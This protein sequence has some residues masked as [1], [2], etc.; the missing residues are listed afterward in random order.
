MIILS[1]TLLIGLRSLQQ[2]RTLWRLLILQI[3]RV[4]LTL[5][6]HAETSRENMAKRSFSPAIS[7]RPDRRRAIHA[8]YSYCR[9]ADDIVDR[10]GMVGDEITLAALDAWEA[11]IERPWHP[12]AVS[13]AETRATYGIPSQPAHDLLQ[14]V[15][16]DLEPVHFETWSA[17]REYCYQVAGTVGLLTAPVLGCE[18]E[19]ALP[20]AVDLGIAMQMTNIIRDVGEDIGL[21]RIYLPDEDLDQFGVDRSA[22]ENGVAT[23]DFDGL[24]AFEIAR[25][26]GYYE[27]GL[28]GVPAL[29]VF[30]Q[31]AVLT[32]ARLYGSILDRV[33]DQGFDVLSRRAYVPT[34]RKFTAMPLVA[35]SF[36]QLRIER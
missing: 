23:G 21:G 11:Q 17:L 22:L 33:E 8:I 18:N 32:S 16:S 29:S 5:G 15:R 1:K 24:I 7:C 2:V 36:L 25:A 30:G 10:A 31:L 12:V 26:R 9:I 20:A 35:F 19:R 14:G 34:F 27:S 6:R 3:F 13:F 4:R 28:R